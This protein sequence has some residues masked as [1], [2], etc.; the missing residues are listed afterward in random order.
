MSA[1]RKPVMWR[2]APSVVRF[3]LQAGVVTAFALA[4]TGCSGSD[5]VRGFGLHRSTPDEYTVTTRAPLS[6][7]PSEILALPGAANAN[8][9]DESPRM[10][11][12]ETLAPDVALHPM[13]GDPSSGQTTLVHNVDR[14]AHAPDNAELGDA[15][16]GF[17][18]SLMFWQG[19]HAG[20][21]VDGEAENQR[22]Q[23]DSALGH[24]F[25]YGATP[26]MR[27]H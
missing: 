27:G 19:G 24:P 4:L 1:V 20:S 14:A 22:I 18:N 17:V 26:T 2:F 5:V 10:Q 15:D 25:N 11:A 23:N 6:M 12:L 3:G 21:V 9:P 8:R 16:V 7:P 13:Q